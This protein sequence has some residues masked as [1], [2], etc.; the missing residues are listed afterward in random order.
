MAYSQAF[1]NMY[2][3]FKELPF[4]NERKKTYR[5]IDKEIGNIGIQKRGEV[6]IV[7]EKMQHYRCRKQINPNFS[8]KK[9]EY[10]SEYHQ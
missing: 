9:N 8:V 6:K 5:N 2:R 7:Q 10:K 4:G 3:L 1:E